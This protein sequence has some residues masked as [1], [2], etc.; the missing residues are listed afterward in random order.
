MGVQL[1]CP[2]PWRRLGLGVIDEVL[3]IDIHGRYDAMWALQDWGIDQ[4]H[5]M[6]SSKIES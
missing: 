3:D 6:W 2:V 1:S 4:V 5:P